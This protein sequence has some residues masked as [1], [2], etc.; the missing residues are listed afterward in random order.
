MS[1]T[2][3]LIAL[4]EDIGHRQ[5]GLGWAARGHARRLQRLARY[6]R[7][8]EDQL[9][10]LEGFSELVEALELLDSDTTNR[11]ADLIVGAWQEA[12]RIDR[13]GEAQ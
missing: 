3:D 7:T 9:H 4:L 13:E 12:W 6:T 10:K 8:R 11:L 1:A 2:N 5:D